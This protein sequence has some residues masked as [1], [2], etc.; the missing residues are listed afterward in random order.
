[1]STG[2]GLEF[3]LRGGESWRNP[4]DSYRWLRE[5]DPVHR[6]EH[7]IY[8]NFWIYSRFEDVFEA[9]RNTDTYSSAQGLTPDKDAMKAF[10]GNAAPI[11]MMDPPEHTD[12]RRIVSHLMTPRRVAKFENEI[13][14]Y[15]NKKIEIILDPV[16][17]THLTLPTKRIV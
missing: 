8:G 17:Y 3:R 4:Y 5:E 13:R 2:K 7:P 14:R 15:I 11:V 1:M 12:F 16:S 10:E 6:V 9:V